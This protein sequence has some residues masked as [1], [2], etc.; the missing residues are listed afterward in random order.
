ME[1][2]FLTESMGEHELWYKE[3]HAIRTPDELLPFITKLMTCYSHDMTTVCHAI[4]AGALAAVSVMNS[5]PEGGLTPSQA[6]KLLGLFIRKYAKMQGP[7][8]I[9]QWMGLLN[10]SNKDSFGVIPKNV[11]TEVRLQAAELLLAD[12]KNRKLETSGLSEHQKKEHASA[13]LSAEQVLHLKS[14]KDGVVPW[15]LRVSN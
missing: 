8:T 13:L 3:A 2:K 11:W 5:F 9:V 12:E 6:Q 1:P 7:I 14:I 4:T 15:G 10:S